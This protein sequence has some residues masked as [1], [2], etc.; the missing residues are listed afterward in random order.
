MSEG[1]QFARKGAEW[2]PPLYVDVDGTLLKSDLLFESI[3]LLLKRN[4][5][6]AFLLPLWL[7]LGKA[8]LKREIA[9]RVAL[10]PSLLPYNEKLVASL[11]EEKARGR[12][13]VLAS[14]SDELLVRPIADHFGFFQGFIASDG[15]TNLKGDNKRLAIVA[16]SNNGV[17]AYA[18]NDE[19]DLP[20]WKD[21]R[22]AWVVSDSPK[23]TQK[24][25]AM[26]NDVR[27]FEA[28][29]PGLK[30]YGRLIRVHQWTK[31]AIVFVPL[32]TSHQ[33]MNRALLR[34]S[35]L[36]A[37]AFCLV[38]SIIYIIND[39]LDLDA[40]RVHATKRNRPLASGKASIA[41]AAVFIPVFAAGA[42]VISWQLPLGFA[43]T[44]CG[45]LVLTL[46]Y[47]WLL[48]RL[49][50]VDAICLAFLY[51][52][53]IVAGQEATG[54]AYSTWLMAFAMFLFFS[55]ALLKRHSELRR[56]PLST[57]VIRGRGYESADEA[58]VA[59]LG[60]SSGAVAVLVVALYADS[61]AVQSIYA[62]PRLLLLLCPIFLYWIGRFWI[63]SFRGEPIDDPVLFAIKDPRSYISGF[64][65]LA[66]IA[67][68]S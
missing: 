26:V 11:R 25:A 14:A 42:V 56:F 47:S 64:L 67:L 23:L 66:V 21:C 36:A 13:L 41:S 29:A 60:V 44:L 55:L 34:D 7:I 8:R 5:L 51:S 46:A 68:A 20:I 6:F 9:A 31:N 2:L 18:G 22:Q 30:D 37:F 19:V 59:L 62:Y 58:P 53:R 35:L 27:V 15:K 33:L 49:V 57:K 54:I 52:L 38:A 61:E 39:I 10:S 1:E 28:E 50:L 48:K 3:A 12:T 40:D 16:H 32:L 45:Y 43:A 17:Y 63:S 4:P 24:V 65:A